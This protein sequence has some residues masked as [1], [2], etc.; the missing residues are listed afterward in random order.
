MGWD[1]SEWEEYDQW[2]SFFSQETGPDEFSGSKPPRLSILNTTQQS[3]QTNTAVRPDEYAW[4]MWHNARYKICIKLFSGIALLRDSL[5]HSL[6]TDCVTP[7]SCHLPSTIAGNKLGLGCWACQVCN[8]LQGCWTCWGHVLLNDMSLCRHKNKMMAWR[9]SCVLQD[10]SDYRCSIPASQGK[11]SHLC[12]LYSLP[13]FLPH[14]GYPAFGMGCWGLVWGGKKTRKKKTQNN[15][16]SWNQR[17]GEQCEKWQRITQRH[18][19]TRHS[20]ALASHACLC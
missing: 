1:S 20:R 6:F 10:N 4:W 2:Q 14:A 15:A 17:R 11:S 16:H 7:A 8:Y 18:C 13:L 9:S 19:L 3:P 5:D 12:L